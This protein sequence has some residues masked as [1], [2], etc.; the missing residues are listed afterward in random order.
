MPKMDIKGHATWDNGTRSF[1]VMAEVDR[2]LNGHIAKAGDAMTDAVLL[3]QNTIA[4][5]G[6]PPKKMSNSAL[7]Y[8][9]RY[10]LTYLK[11]DAAAVT[12][13]TRIF[14][15]TLNGLQSN[16]MA[17]KIHLRPFDD[18]NGKVTG[19]RTAAGQPEPSTKPFHTNVVN[20]KDGLEWRKGAIH[21]YSPRLNQ[22]RDGVRT[23]IH[24]ATHK[25]AGTEDYHYL[26][27]SGTP[28]SG[29]TDPQ[30]ALR[31]ADSYAWFAINV[32]CKVGK[33]RNKM[34]QSLR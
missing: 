18:A 25:Y 6:R 15:Q 33:F 14:I 9:H 8:G 24:E 21:I 7:I 2:A 32:G 1:P 17:L 23:L 22:G 31:N 20:L 27:G 10:F 16:S 28:P 29:F 26:D 11:T 30:R 5:L 19:R 4:E 34:F 12:E 13:C 3:L